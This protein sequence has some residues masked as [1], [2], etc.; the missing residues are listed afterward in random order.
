MK[1][2]TEGQS[3]ADEVPVLILEV[4]D[5]AQPGHKEKSMFSGEGRELPMHIPLLSKN[6][7]SCKA[8]NLGLVNPRTEDKIFFPLQH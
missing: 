5:S 2:N 8:A 1:T 3:P 6:N 4:R 7:S